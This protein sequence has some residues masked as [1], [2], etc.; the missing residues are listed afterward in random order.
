MSEWV[1]IDGGNGDD[2]LIQAGF[3]ESPDP[4]NPNDVIIQPWWEILPSAETYIT[5]VQISPDD[6]VTVS[7]VQISGTEWGITLTDDTDG[8]SFTIDRTYTGPAATAEWI[9]EALTVGGEVATLA[10]Y[11]PVVNFSSLGFSAT[12]T[13]LQ[14]VVMVQS[15]NQVSTPSTLT[16]DGFSVAYGN[17]APSPPP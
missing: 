7:I 12:G 14:E 1:G 6:E 13:K 17:V 11:S 2:S 9:L 4:T 3:N 10:P 8:E 15:G 5:S 16:A